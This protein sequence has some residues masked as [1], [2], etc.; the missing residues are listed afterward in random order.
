MIEAVGSDAEARKAL[1]EDL[2][3]LNFAVHQPTDRALFTATP[4]P[5]MRPCHWK[6]SDIAT[7]LKRIGDEVRLEAGGVRRTL[8]LT[9]PGLEFGTTPTF[10]A[11]IQYI[12]P[13]EVATAHRHA[14]TAL[15]FIMH[16]SGANTIVDGERFWMNEGD[17]VLTPS[18]AYHDHEHLGDEPMIWLD[19]LDISLT[20]AFD[21]VS[22]EGS[23]L[24]RRPLNEFPDRSDREYGSA[25]MAPLG[26]TP[27]FHNPMLVY[28]RKRAREAVLAASELPAHPF[29]DTALEYRN[30]F[31]GG[32]ATTTLGLVLQR[33]R[34]GIELAPFRKTG[35]SVYYVISGNGKVQIDET[36]FDWG[37][38][39]FISIP[40]WAARSFSNSS[41]SE[42]AWLFQVDD[43]PALQALNLWRESAA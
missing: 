9:N 24:A 31:R 20:R 34:P 17:L 36:R 41:P 6:A 7:W 30:P 35:S 39:D 40:S 18:G 11:S 1:A 14:A 27:K 42:D 22:F 38:G 43:R 29:H 21:A 28:D 25:I 3:K 19:V 16:G 26:G 2:A 13:G 15:R 33:L 8:R 12:L 37:P 23:D 5:A 32:P 10:W 4:Q